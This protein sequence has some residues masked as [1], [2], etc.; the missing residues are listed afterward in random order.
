[1]STIRWTQCPGPV[2]WRSND[3]RYQVD[4]VHTDEGLR[5]RAI[6]LPRPMAVDW[7]GPLRV[8]AE[9]AKGDALEHAYGAEKLGAARAAP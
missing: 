1:M 2:A 5:Y 6:H 7:T 3:W 4:T 9:E 8:T